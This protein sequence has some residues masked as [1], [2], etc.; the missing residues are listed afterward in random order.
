MK[1]APRAMRAVRSVRTKRSLPVRRYL[2]SMPCV[3]PN[4]SAPRKNRNASSFVRQIAL[5]PIRIGLR[6][7]RSCRKNT[8]SFIPEQLA[9]GAMQSVRLKVYSIDGVT[10][11]IHPLAFV[12]PEAV[13]IGDVIVEEGCY[14]GPCAS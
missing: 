10:P 8:N 6:R 2:P 1:T 4:V 5:S 3:A 14:I 12:H 9:G 11:V 13:L 7:R